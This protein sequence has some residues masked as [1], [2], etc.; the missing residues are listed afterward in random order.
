MKI[1]LFFIS[2]L[3]TLKAMAQ[4]PINDN[5]AGA[6][7]VNV[8]SGCNIIS[9]NNANATLSL[10]AHSCNGNAG[11]DIWYKCIVPT[12][13]NIQLNSIK[14]TV[15]DVIASIYTGTCPSLSEVACDDDGEESP[16]TLMPKLFQSGLTAGETVY[17]K[18]SSF[19]STN[20]TNTGSFSFCIKD[21]IIPPPPTPATNISCATAT[22]LTVSAT[23]NYTLTNNIGAPLSVDSLACPVNIK[24]FNKNVW[25]KFTVPASGNA[26]ITTTAGTLSDAV[27]VLYTGSDC[28]TLSSISCS[29][30]DGP[31]AMPEILATNLVP[32][33]TAYLKIGDFVTFVSSTPQEGTFNICI[34]DTT[35]NASSIQETEFNSFLIYPNP[36]QNNITIHSETIIN[37]TIFIFNQMGAIVYNEK[38]ENFIGSKNINLTTLAKG[39]YFIKMG[40]ITKKIILE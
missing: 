39:I 15:T 18:F 1:K 38:L 26:F 10:P 32:G 14:G 36:A 23:C 35:V 5:C 11:F 9:A 25:Y 12:S 8:G 3:L 7:L 33:S 24:R 29:D 37:S 28:N 2:A 13:G 22:N 34:K 31:V 19:D 6:I 21:S 20:V 4:A 40:T 17:L 16:N 30:D 27:M